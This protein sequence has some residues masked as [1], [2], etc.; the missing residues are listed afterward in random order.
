VQRVSKT[1]DDQALAVPRPGRQVRLEMELDAVPRALGDVQSVVR[2]GEQ[3]DD[4]EIPVDRGAADARG[5]VRRAVGP[6][7][8]CGDRRADAVSDRRDLRAVDLFEGDR[9]LV[10]SDPSVC[11]NARRLRRS[12]SGS[13][14][15]RC[16]SRRVSRAPLPRS[17]AVP[18]TVETSPDTSGAVDRL[19]STAEPSG[20]VTTTASPSIVQPA[21]A[22]SRRRRI[23]REPPSR[24]TSAG[25]VFPTTSVACHPK[26]R[27]A[28]RFHTS[29][30]PS[31]THS[32]IAMGA[33]SIQCPGTME[34]GESFRPCLL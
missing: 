26:R 12:V 25:Q 29:V 10:A 13:C 15:A 28:A 34:R 27:S 31:S 5:D 18:T 17:T 4:A 22:S 8:E 3:F 11:S 6:G 7:V 9:E 30:C 14:V 19:T 1:R 32:K 16:M 24:C 2:G 23:S 20:R 21:R 33:A